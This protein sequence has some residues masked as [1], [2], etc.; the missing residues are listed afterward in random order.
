VVPVGLSGAAAA[1]RTRDRRDRNRGERSLSIMPEK[2]PAGV[3]LAPITIEPGRDAR[4]RVTAPASALADM[5]IM[6]LS[7]NDPDHPTLDVALGV[8]IGG[9]DPGTVDE[10]TA[11]AGGCHTGGGAVGWM[12][13]LGLLVALRRR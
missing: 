5:Q 4:L 13:A 3:L 1:E 10:P 12:F 7:S 2:I 9:T 11:E 6:T 8:D